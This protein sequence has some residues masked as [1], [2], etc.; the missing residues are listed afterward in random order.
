MAKRSTKRRSSAS[1]TPAILDASIRILVLC[2]PEPMQ[3]QEAFNQLKQALSK[4]H[5]GIEV[6]HFDGRSA[7]LAEVFDELRTFSLM[8]TY[9]LVVV[10]D[11]EVFVKAHRDALERYAAEP[12]DNATLVMRSVNWNSPKL[13]KLIAKVGVKVKAE[14]MKP[15]AAKKWAVDRAK[16]VHERTLP[17]GVAEAFVQR[18]GGDLMRLDSEL[19]KLALLV[20]PD[21]PITMDLI[22]QMVGRSSDEKAWAVQEAVLQAIQSA[23]RDGPLS[24]GAAIEKLH[25]LVDLSGQPD[26]LVGYFVAD[27]VRKLNL[28]MQL[29]R[30][31][32]N[33]GAIAS[34][35]KIWPR[36]RQTLF[37]GLM[38][39]L[40]ERSAGQLFDRIVESDVRSKS[41]LGTAMRNLECF[42][43][44]LADV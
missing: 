19:A 4:A 23:S 26:V 5:G 17:D 27:L 13:D 37:F 12:V 1:S 44:S 31:G 25:E 21:Q 6:Y 20:E 11:A 33:E 38:R 16:Q 2:G 14:P 29:R 28:A 39:R 9:K 34:Q 8:Q 22:E 41:G 10:D 32:M 35:M 3:K 15:A 18:L 42:C 7:A 40:D 36:E 24:G 43:A 30:Q